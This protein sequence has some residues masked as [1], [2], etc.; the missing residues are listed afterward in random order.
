MHNFN[1]V[2]SKVTGFYNDICQLVNR[3]A[4]ILGLASSYTGIFGLHKNKTLNRYPEVRTKHQIYRAL[5]PQQAG[6]AL[7]PVDNRHEREVA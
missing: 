7:S 3:P 6:E 4:V 5:S 1:L 2:S